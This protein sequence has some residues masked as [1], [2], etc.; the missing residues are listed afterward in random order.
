M[1]RRDELGTQK[2]AFKGR[3]QIF[4]WGCL[5][6]RGGINARSTE[7]AGGGGQQKASTHSCS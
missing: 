3:Y 4:C 7:G 5:P 2:S 1:R 6:W